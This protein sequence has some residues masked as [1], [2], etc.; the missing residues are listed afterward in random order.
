M[1]AIRMPLPILLLA[2]FVVTAT[3]GCDSNA[4]SGLGDCPSD[5][6]RT[7]DFDR[8]VGAATNPPDDARFRAQ[9]GGDDIAGPAAAFANLGS[10]V[11][12]VDVLLLYY[13]TASGRPSADSLVRFQLYLPAGSWGSLGEGDD[14]VVDADYFPPGTLSQSGTGKVRLDRRS[15]DRVEVTFAACVSPSRIQPIRVPSRDVLRGS[16]TVQVR[17]ASSVSTGR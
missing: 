12:T 16:A 17:Q 9:F 10:S 8:T 3:S 11:Q 5:F 14:M 13:E 2:A 1:C 15:G 4:D 6:G 7:I